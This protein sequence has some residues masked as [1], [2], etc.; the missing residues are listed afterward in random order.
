MEKDC[1][2]S[3]VLFLAFRKACGD[4]DKKGAEIK[5]KAVA[6]LESQINADPDAPKITAEEEPALRVELKGTGKGYR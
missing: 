5:D 6:F 4:V 1:P 2:D 3:E